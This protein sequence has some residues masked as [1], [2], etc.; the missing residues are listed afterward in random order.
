MSYRFRG[1]SGTP[2]DRVMGLAIAA[3]GAVS[4]DIY[5]IN[6]EMQAKH[7]KLVG[8]IGLSSR[9][10]NFWKQVRAEDSL[11]QEANRDG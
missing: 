10:I 11:I 3:Y 6:M 9:E 1:E 7:A 5:D 8:D 2:D 4:G